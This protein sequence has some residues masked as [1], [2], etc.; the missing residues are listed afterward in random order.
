MSA[1]PPDRSD[2]GAAPARPATPPRSAARGLFWAGGILVAAA[3]VLVLAGL[4]LPFLAFPVESFTQPDTPPDVGEITTAAG[5][6]AV[7]VTAVFLGMACGLVGVVLLVVGAVRHSRSPRPRLAPGSWSR[8]TAT[9][10]TPRP[11]TLPPPAPPA[12]PAQPPP[13]RWP[14]PPPAQ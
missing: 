11:G 4:V 7:G 13:A 6:V 10:V 12:D 5:G 1:P 2:P 3:L 14:P 8:A 9:P